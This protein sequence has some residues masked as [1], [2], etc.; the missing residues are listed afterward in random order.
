M[1]EEEY[2]QLAGHITEKLDNTAEY[3]DWLIIQDYVDDLQSGL[4]KERLAYINLKKTFD[5]QYEENQQLKSKLEKQSNICVADH[6]YAS[7]KED[8]VI[9]LKQQLK[10]RDDVIDE[11]IVFIKKETQ[12]MSA[13]LGINKCINTYKLLSILNKRGGTDE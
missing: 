13:G 11:A 7:S 10:Q 1:S 8:E 12:S 3:E 4:V 6:K 9:E 2:L 5:E